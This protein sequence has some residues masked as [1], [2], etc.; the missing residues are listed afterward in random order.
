MCSNFESSGDIKNLRNYFETQNRPQTSNKRSKRPTDKALIFNIEN[1]VRSLTWGI[2]QPWLGETNARPIINARMETLAQKK[3]FRSIINQRCLIP[4]TAWFEWRRSGGKRIKNR[5]AV[6][7]K[8][9]FVFAGLA[10]ES[11]FTIITCEAMPEIAHIHKRMPMVLTPDN[12]N[13]WF[14]IQTPF[15]SMAKSIILQRNFSLVFDE[16]K[17][18]Q[19]EMFN[20]L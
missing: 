9:P 1:K 17:P 11:Y 13:K 10:N 18:S 20:Q 4:A 8:V 5:I 2:P 16:E 15:E 6:R 12:V 19:I 14:D 3:T 7:D